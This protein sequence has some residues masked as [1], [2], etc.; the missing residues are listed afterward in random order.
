MKLL[1]EGVNL[2][3]ANQVAWSDDNSLHPCYTP[4]CTVN[5]CGPCTTEPRYIIACL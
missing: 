3:E 1:N 2:Y 4:V 5:L